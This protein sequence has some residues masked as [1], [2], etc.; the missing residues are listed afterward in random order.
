MNN[1]KIDKMKLNMSRTTPKP[2]A[3]HTALNKQRPLEIKPLLPMAVTSQK[4]TQKS[5][6]KPATTKTVTLSK[7]RA[8]TATK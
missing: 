8:R 2:M 3:Q 1:F 7:S 5:I 4:A 6:P